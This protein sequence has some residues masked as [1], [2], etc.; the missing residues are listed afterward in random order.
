MCGASPGKPDKP[1]KM[2]PKTVFCKA[3]PFSNWRKGEAL[4]DAGQKNK[5]STRPAKILPICE[6]FCLPNQ[7]PQGCTSQKPPFSNLPQK[8]ASQHRRVE[9]TQT[10]HIGKFL[11]R[12][13]G[14]LFFC[15][16]PAFR[17]F[18]SKRGHFPCKKARLRVWED[19]ERCQRMP[20]DAK[21]RLLFLYMYEA[22]SRFR[23]SH[24]DIRSRCKNGKRLLWKGR[25]L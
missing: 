1:G 24:I 15:R 4:A 20:K 25:M 19:A 2:P 10:S 11:A 8:V 7:Q 16:H 3:F 13:A 18:P 22:A 6:V 9:R 21:G 12:Q 14:I 17:P 5:K 23:N